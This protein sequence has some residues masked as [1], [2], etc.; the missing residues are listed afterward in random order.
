MY[1]QILKTAL[2]FV[3]DKNSYEINRMNTYQEVIS[4]LK[5]IGKLKKGEKV[6]TKQMYIQEE[7]IMTTI[8]RTFWVKDNRLN[9]INF[10]H[11]TV[12]YSFELLYNYEKSKHLTEQEIAKNIINDLRKVN[13]GLENLKQTY[14]LDTKFCCDM[15]TLIEDINSRLL[16]YKD[17]FIEDEI[18]M[19]DESE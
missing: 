16:V 15:D 9:T 6:N 18:I 5:F 7:G 12:K 13:K 19:E 17:K 10:I 14:V 1:S 11:E 2:I 4:K 3:K 8:S